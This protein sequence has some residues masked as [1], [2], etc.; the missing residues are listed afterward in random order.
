MRVLLVLILALVAPAALAKE[1]WT[2][3][4]GD[5]EIE[6]GSVTVADGVTN[7]WMRQNGTEPHTMQ[8]KRGAGGH[9]FRIF[10]AGAWSGW[11]PVPP[12]SNVAA[13]VPVAKFC[14]LFNFLGISLT[15]SRNQLTEGW[16]PVSD[17]D[18]YYKDFYFAEDGSLLCC[19]RLTLA[20]PPGEKIVIPIKF[21]VEGGQIYPDRL[22]ETGS[23]WII[24]ESPVPKDSVVYLIYTSILNS[25]APGY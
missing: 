2:S 17:K 22:D 7:F 12:G 6:S 18:E 19:W 4:I 11:E 9:L 8:I 3:V 20:D 5:Y 21:R 24:A 16:V 1:Y 25:G 23:N 10:A 14:A 15:R 13:V